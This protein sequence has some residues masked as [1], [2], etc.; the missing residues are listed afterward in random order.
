VTNLQSGGGLYAQR[1]VTRKNYDLERA[2]ALALKAAGLS[3]A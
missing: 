3:G 1:L 2:R